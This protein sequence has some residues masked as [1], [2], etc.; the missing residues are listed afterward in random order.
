LIHDSA[1]LL[2]FRKEKETSKNE[3]GSQSSGGNEAR[4]EYGSNQ[5]EERKDIIILKL[6]N[7]L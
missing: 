3:I 4:V 2:G 5:V 6:P 1:F 7:R